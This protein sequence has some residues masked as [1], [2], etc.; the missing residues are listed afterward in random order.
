M[1]YVEKGAISMDGV[2]EKIDVIETYVPIMRNDLFIGAFEI[3]YDITERK[4]RQSTLI[5]RSKIILIS[6]AFGLILFMF[7]IL[8][9]ASENYARREEA[10]IQLKA[11]KEQAESASK[12]KSEFLASMSHEIRTPMNGV[13][14]V[15]ELLH[16]TE[17]NDTQKEYVNVIETDVP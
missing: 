1:A 6:T 14:G 15:A 12:A 4:Y 7:V 2:A 11:A 5:L 3:Y 17:L 9:Q 10:E 16:H 13:L 8:R